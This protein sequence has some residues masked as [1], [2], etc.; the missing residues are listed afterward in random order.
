[1]VILKVLLIGVTKFIGGGEKVLEIISRSLENHEIDLITDK[2]HYNLEKYNIKFTTLYSTSLT[3][4][5]KGV[6][7][8]LRRLMVRR[9]INEISKGKKYDIIINN[10][11]RVFLY[12][13]DVN[14]LHGFSFLDNYI[15]EYGNLKSKKVPF[16]MKTLK[17][18][19][20]YNN[21]NFLTHGNYTLNLAFKLFPE[22]GVKPRR[23]DKILLPLEKMDKVDLKNKENLILTFGRISEDKQLTTVIDI[24]K[25]MRNHTFIISGSVRRKEEKDF[26]NYL[27]SIAPDNVKIIPNPTEEE[28]ENLYKKAWVY[29]HTK[30]KEHFGLTVVEAISYGSVP[31]VPKA[32]E[33]WIDIVEEGKYGFGYNSIEEGVEA[34][35]QALGLPREDREFILE[36]RNRFSFDK[37]KSNFLNYIEEIR[38]Y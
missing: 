19:G 28:K 7:G 9:E 18:Y 10:N 12:K 20:M 4:E 17:I 24:A 2:F 6:L 36:S 21:A 34:V 8:Y 33:P 23:I 1:V 29:L 15:D 26:F 14:Y 37:F 22:I 31:V 11:P 25:V 3:L 13:G 16:L 27:K 30:R 5:E 38:R 32:G 35:K